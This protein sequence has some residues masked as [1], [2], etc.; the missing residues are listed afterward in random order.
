MQCGLQTGMKWRVLALVC[1]FSADVL[2]AQDDGAVAAQA[3]PSD[4]QNSTLAEFTRG[5]FTPTQSA[6]FALAL[7]YDQAT[8]AVP[9]WGSGRAG[10]DRRAEWLAA[11]YLSRYSAEFAAEK[12][13]GTDT[14]YQRCHCKGFPKRAA[15][16]LHAEFTERTAEGANVFAFARMSGIVAST[17]VTAPMLPERYGLADAGS[18]AITAIG[19]DEGFN[20][21]Q[22]FWPEI[23]RTL[24][25]RKK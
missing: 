20:V 24:L 3:L 18:R 17:A 1:L 5:L 14:S 11:T 12:L 7:L 10:L 21:L 9:E 13:L 25:L 2:L 16:A 22:E 4:S 15:H 23:K 8:V 19:V 6:K